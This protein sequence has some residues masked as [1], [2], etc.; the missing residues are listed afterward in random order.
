MEEAAFEG[1]GDHQA[2][3]DAGDDQGEGERTE[4]MGDSQGRLWRIAVLQ[5]GDEAS[6]VVHE[7][8]HETQQSAALGVS[9]CEVLCAVGGGWGG[10]H[11]HIKN[12]F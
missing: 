10:V 1:G 2:A 4:A 8:A 5:R 12:I 3:G 7:F 6:A 9:L 11:E